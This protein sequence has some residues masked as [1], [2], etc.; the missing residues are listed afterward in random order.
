M[1]FRRLN[2]AI[3]SIRFDRVPP[4]VTSDMLERTVLPLYGD[5][6]EWE[7]SLRRYISLSQLEAKVFRDLDGKIGCEV[8]RLC[9]LGLFP[10]LFV[11]FFCWD[12]ERIRIEINHDTLRKFARKGRNMAMTFASARSKDAYGFEFS[13]KFMELLARYEF[14]L[15]IV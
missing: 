1:S 6:L 7:Y 14:S 4:A 15:E 10:V 3:A 9:R 12:F 5:I 2:V 8:L 13:D 11:Q